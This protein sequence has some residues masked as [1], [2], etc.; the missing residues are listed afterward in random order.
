MGKQTKAHRHDTIRMKI[1]RHEK[2]K[3]LQVKYQT[4]DLKTREAVLVKLHKI[5]ATLPGEIKA[6]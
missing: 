3:K 1:R 4:A 6:R 2:I 5:N